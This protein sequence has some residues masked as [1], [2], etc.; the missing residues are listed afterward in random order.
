VRIFLLL[1]L[2]LTACTNGER[3]LQFNLGIEVVQLDWNKAIDATSV[4]LLDNVMEGLTTYSNALQGYRPDLLRPLPALA[5]SWSVSD[6]GTVYRFHL[7]PG[8]RWTDGQPLV[9]QAF[10]DSWRRLLDPE[11]R[12]ANAYHLFDIENARAF[13]EGKLKDFSTVG[14]RAVDD[15][16]L[17]VKLRRQAPY[18]L[19]VSCP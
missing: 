1:C 14:V 15:L 10:V 13:N 17:E 16:T 3:P 5:A 8:V 19:H 7:R 18:F 12:S 2:F 9:A 6:G 11:T 4:V